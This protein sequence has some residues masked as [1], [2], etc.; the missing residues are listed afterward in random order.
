MLDTGSA[1]TAR[2]MARIGLAQ[3]DA[4]NALEVLCA[5]I[6]LADLILLVHTQRLDTDTDDTKIFHTQHKCLCQLFATRAA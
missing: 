2:S 3:F 5:S 4:K 1:R 6:P